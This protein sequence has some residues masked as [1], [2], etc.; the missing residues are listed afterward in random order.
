M[1]V[2]VMLDSEYW[3]IQKNAG[4]ADILR[5]EEYRGLFPKPKTENSQ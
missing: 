3:R 2:G 5:L 1:R 4:K